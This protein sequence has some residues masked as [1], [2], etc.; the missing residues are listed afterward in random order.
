[1]DSGKYLV[2]NMT[3]LSPLPK[4]GDSCRQLGSEAASSEP[5]SRR[6]VEAGLGRTGGSCAHSQQVPRRAGASHSPPS[7]PWEEVDPKGP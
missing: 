3:V 1:M 4:G 2:I 6:K 7:H 5:D